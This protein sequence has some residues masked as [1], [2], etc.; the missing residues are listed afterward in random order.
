MA[1]VTATVPCAG[2]GRHEAAW[3]R[4][5]E[6]TREFVAR[7]FIS[8]LFV[9][10]ATSIASEYVRTGHVTGLLLLVSET[11]VVVMTA[12]RRPAVIIDL[13]WQARVVA[14]VSI[15][16]VPLIRPIGDALMPDMYTAARL[17][18]GARCNHHGQAHPGPEL[19]A[20]AR[21]SWP[22]VHRHLRMGPA[23]DLRRVPGH[24]R[25]HSSL[26]TRPGGTWCC[27]S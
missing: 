22:R 16:G 19:R 2:V 14:A 24:T 25:L 10:L 6:R 9:I 18:R 8:S 4:V 26:P 13:T 11:L 12:V 15:L 5:P 20:H 17:R 7:A 21:A 3:S 27:S 1:G 23:P